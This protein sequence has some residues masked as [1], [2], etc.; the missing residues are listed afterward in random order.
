MKKPI[1]MVHWMDP[2]GNEWHS[3]FDTDEDFA[4]FIA[5]LKNENICFYTCLSG[6]SIVPN[7]ESTRLIERIS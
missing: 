4:D 2:E 6:G 7:K 3:P 1:A 5:R